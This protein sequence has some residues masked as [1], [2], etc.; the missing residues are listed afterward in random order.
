MP[1]LS[2]K[3]LAFSILEKAYLFGTFIYCLN[4]KEVVFLTRDGNTR[5]KD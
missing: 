2:N 1:L 3:D 5:G 4:E